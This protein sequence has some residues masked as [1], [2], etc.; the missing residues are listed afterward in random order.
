[1]ITFFDILVVAAIVGCAYWGWLMG[2]EAAGV[3]AL[4]LLACLSVAVILHEPLA[5]FLHAGFTSVLGDW[6]GS[7]WSVL[8]AFSLLA[9]GPFALLRSQFHRLDDDGDHDVAE[10]DPLADRVAGAVAGGIGGAVIAGGV[11]VTLSMVPFLAGLKPSGDR[12]LLDVGK[13]VLR[14]AGSFAGERH[15][16][17][18]VPVWGEPPSR[19]SVASARLTSEP[20][21]DTDDDG[22][23][24]DADRFRDVDGNGTFTKDLYFVDVDDDGLR[25]I[26]LID[27]YVVG[28]WDGSLQSNDRPRPESVKPVPPPAAVPQKVSAP[29]PPAGS[30]ID[31][32][33]DVDGSDAKPQDQ[34]TSGTATPSGTATTTATGTAPGMGAENKPGT[35]SGPA[36]IEVPATN[37]TENS[38]ASPEASSP[39]DGP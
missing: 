29:P 19:M 27:K 3:A 13:L 7:A 22:T 32:S 39:T 14:A 38:P 33:A 8:L 12:M 5:G 1:M 35:A 2:L 9:W 23:F 24:T 30:A 4:E 25:R 28:R 37:A 11:L 34:S 16:G 17:R 10:I 36:S 26:G 21:F 6:I 31:R 20:W 18:S 15:E